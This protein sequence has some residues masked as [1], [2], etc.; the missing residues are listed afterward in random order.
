MGMSSKILQGTAWLVS[1]RLA[2][3]I[4][5]LVSTAVLVRLL[6]PREFGIVAAAWI[7]MSLANVLFDGAFGQNLIRKRVV[8]DEDVRTTLTMGIALGLMLM[9]MVI[10][11]AKWI[12]SFFDFNDLDLVLIVSSALIPCKAVFAI[13]TSQLQRSGHFKVMATTTLVTQI[14]GNFVVAIP[15]AF[16]NAGVWSLVVGLVISGFAEALILGIIA[17]LPC[18]PMWEREAA[19]DVFSSGFFSIAN[20]MNWAGNTGA[21]AVVGKMMGAVSLGLY[22]RGWKLLDIFVAATATPLS[23]VI[24][25][26]FARLRNEN[27][28]SGEALTEILSIVLPTYAIASVLLTL[29]APLIVYLALGP[30][31]DDT[32]PV[33]QILFATLVPRCAVKVS[34]NFAV[35]AGHSKSTALRQ[36]FYAI[37]MISGTTI[38]TRWGIIGVSI[39]ASVAICSFY[40]V[41]ILYAMKLGKVRLV[42][43]V[44][45]HAKTI[46]L[47]SCTLA[48][49]VAAQRLVSSGFMILQHMLSGFLALAGTVGL[50]ALRPKFWVGDNNANKLRRLLSNRLWQPYFGRI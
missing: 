11:S 27:A 1:G 47:V 19:R 29:H 6:S 37:L 41:S 33:A 30:K 14:I 18:R 46:I 34:E 44:S 4:L 36:G 35:A 43:V 9:L 26:I 49:D 10:A 2:S 48:I 38:G 20:I 31:F 25:P 32:V 22:S 7:V 5:S 42:K 28:N 39:A 15:L 24:L 17:R 21:N 45:L 3:A 16:L 50:F 40:L 12:S 13:A 23:R 8:R